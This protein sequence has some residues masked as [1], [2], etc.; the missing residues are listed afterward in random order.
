META[1]TPPEQ[2]DGSTRPLRLNSSAA[3]IV[4]DVSQKADIAFRQGSYFLSKFR[5]CAQIDRAQAVQERIDVSNK[6]FIWYRS[7]L[8]YFHQMLGS[9]TA[10]MTQFAVIAPLPQAPLPDF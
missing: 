6:S 10:L 8:L 1:I 2:K 5:I 9:R 3:G 4:V 7:F